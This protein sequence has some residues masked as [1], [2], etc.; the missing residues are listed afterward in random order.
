MPDVPWA[1][2]AHDPRV[3]I[4]I[5]L[6]AVEPPAGVVLPARGDALPF[7]GWL[8]LLRAL[9]DAVAGPARE[10]SHREERSQPPAPSRG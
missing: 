8:G 7:T 10:R 3:L 9:S 4:R 6:D 2:A 1:E 5:R